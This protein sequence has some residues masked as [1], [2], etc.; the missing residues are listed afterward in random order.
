MTDSTP[1]PAALDGVRVVSL[2]P[3]LPGP[4]TVRRLADLGANVTKV[5]SP[6]GDPLHE[7]APQ[8]YEELHRGVTVEVAD[9]KSEAG[10]ARLAEHLGDADLLITSTRP[11]TL[12]RLGLDPV[13]L[14]QT[15]PRLCRIEIVGDA[16]HPEQ[17]GH[18]L[19]YQAAV[20]TLPDR[21]MPRALIADQGGASR[22][23][24]AALVALLHRAA[25]G[26]GSINRVGLVD[27]ATE[28]ADGVRHGI[29]TAQG[30]LGGAFAGYARYATADGEVV[31]ALLEGHL[32]E[33]FSAL[34]GVRLKHEELSALFATRTAH[35]WHQWGLQHEL[36]VVA[37]RAG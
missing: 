32:I 23:V 35:E 17:P 3:N 1:E 12:Q 22:A 15:Y 30:V 19:T 14:A 4:L 10:R 9:L 13:T 8:W 33:T 18:D 6:A 20:G 16:A 21:G 34:T 25:T 27:A 28:F 26:R 2:A 36:P 7:A 24:E 31:V 37:V 29:T 5:E 11:S